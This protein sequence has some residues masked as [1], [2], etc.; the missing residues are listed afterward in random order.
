[1]KKNTNSTKITISLPR[2][3]RE[4][5]KTWAKVASVPLSHA[6]AFMVKRYLSAFAGN[7]G[8]Q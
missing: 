6:A 8:S 4:L 1:M 2:E 5:L 3:Y 7:G